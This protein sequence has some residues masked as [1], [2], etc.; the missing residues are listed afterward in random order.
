MKILAFGDIHMAAHAC[1]AVQD[2]D[3]TD[4]LII[5]G[6]LTN[7][8]GK[9]DAQTVLK[10]IWSYNAH[11][12]CV[13]GNLDTPEVNDYL[14]D[15][16]INLHGQARII[17]QSL[18]VYG[19]GGSNPTPFNTPWEFNES[20]ME[21]LLGEA[22]SHAAQLI[23]EIKEKTGQTLPS[24]CICHTPPAHTTVDKLTNGSHAGSQAVRSHLT[25]FQPTLCIT[26]HIHESKGQD[27]IG[28]TTIYNPGMFADGGYVEIMIQADQITAHLR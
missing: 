28:T 26:G 24:L 15:L 3:K 22:S 4:L 10:K 9:N 1:E 11:T 17:D 20:Q 6:D 5:T 18:C 8:G 23:D 7:F 16:D 12:L 21:L 2:I 14:D 19:M 27:R 13:A 25:D